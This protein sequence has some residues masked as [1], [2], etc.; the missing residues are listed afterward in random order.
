MLYIF[1]GT[2]ITSITTHLCKNLIFKY[3][4]IFLSYNNF[5]TIKSILGSFERPINAKNCGNFY[6]NETNYSTS[7]GM[8][9]GHCILAGYIS[10]YMYI[11][12][13]NNLK[14]F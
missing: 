7:K 5:N 8:P 6:I 9:S 13:N 4:E 11:Y 3:I 14:D 1:I 2:Y 10:I 12:I